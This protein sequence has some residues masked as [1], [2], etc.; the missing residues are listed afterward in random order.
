MD[1]S[2]YEGSHRDLFEIFLK[3]VDD[4]EAQTAALLDLIS[5]EDTRSLLSIGGGEGIVEATLLRN[6]P[7]AKLWYLDPSHEQCQAFRRHMKQENL[8]GRVAD[9]SETTFQTYETQQKFDRIVSM[10]SW[11]YIGTDQRWLRK[12]LDLLSSNGAACLVLPNSESIE[13]DFNRSLSP[14][15]RTMLVGDEVMSALEAFDCKV[16]Q[17]TYMKW[18][19]TNELFD[20]ELA[21][22]ASLAFAAFVALRSITTFTPD[23]KRHIVELLNARRAAQGVPLVWDVIV[24]KRVTDSNGY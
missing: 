20:G 4:S 18:L 8:L 12:L 21:S 7:Q 6:A 22:E 16:T 13:A 14:D 24:V 2:L 23:E 17:H 10:F 19:A 11:F 1:S 3:L 5:W 15:K 9:I